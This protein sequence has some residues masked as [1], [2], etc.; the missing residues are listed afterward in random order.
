MKPVIQQEATGCAIASSAVLAGVSY[1]AAKKVAN[2]LGISATDS[3]L[4]SGTSHIRR[5]LKHYKISTSPP[6]TPFKNWQTLPDS[7]LLAIKWHKENGKAYWHWVVFVRDASGEY[8]LDSK[9]ALKQNVRTDFG[10]I[11]PKWFIGVLNKR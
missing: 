5:I 10:R 7:A 2:S 6:E 1:A 11:K 3:T 9:K 4:W 8:V